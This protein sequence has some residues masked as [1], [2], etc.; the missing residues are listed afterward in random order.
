M[1][2]F[3]SGP[4]NREEGRFDP[5]GMAD[6]AFDAGEIHI[7]RFDL[8]QLSTER[9]QKTLNEADYRRAERFMQQKHRDRFLQGRASLLMLLSA[10]SGRAPNTLELETGPQGKPFLPP[11]YRLGF[12]LSHSENLAVIAIGRQTEIGIDIERRISPDDPLGLAEHAFSEEECRSLAA[13]PPADRTL[14]FFTCWTRKEAFLKALGAGFSL[15]P[16][17]I[18][19]GLSPDLSEIKRPMREETVTVA[20]V[21]AN[22]DIVMSLAVVGSFDDLRL[23]RFTLY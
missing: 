4:E 18:T 10:Y 23:R 16:R 6:D 11:S 2:V 3:A 22:A 9:W 14:A 19:A 12:N 5:A 1:P 17:T 15:D 21:E 20:T 8:D 13:L 7:W